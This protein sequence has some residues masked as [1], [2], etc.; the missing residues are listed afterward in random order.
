MRNVFNTM[1]MNEKSSTIAAMWLFPLLRRAL[2]N[3]SFEGVL[4]PKEFRSVLSLAEGQ[5]VFGLVSDALEKIEVK[6]M[7]IESQITK[8][9]ILETIGR[10][11]QIRRQNALINREQGD[12]ADRCNQEGIEYLVV[13]GQ[14]IGCLYPKPELRQAGDIDFLFPVDLTVGRNKDYE[15]QRS[16]MAKIF[17]EVQLPPKMEEYEVAFNHNGVLYE[18]HTSLRGWAKKRHQEVWDDLM[19]KEW[20]EKN[21]VEIDGVKVRTLSP[22]L[23]AAYVFIH[24][25]FHFIREGVSLRQLCDWA[26]VLHHYN[27]EIDKDKLIRILLELDMFDAYCAFGTILVDELGLP[28]KEFPVSL[29]DNDREWKGKILEDIFRGGNFG[30]LHHQAHSSWKF[31]VETMCV[32]L[33]NSFRYY[34]LCPSEVGGMIPRL[35]KGNL[36]ILLAK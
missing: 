27:A 20:K 29:D 28:K 31:K 7:H 5:T 3:E 1:V 23:N 18:L 16:K 30:K 19:E 33:R 9:A 34:R 4:S 11:Q 22:T 15:M 12:F 2:W 32:A 17:P 21:Y 24:L 6:G 25:F 35:L 10:Q 13:K 26:V 36:K 14:T 8:L